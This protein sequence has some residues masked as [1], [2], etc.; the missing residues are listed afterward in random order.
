MGMRKEM[1]FKLKAY[2]TYS[3]KLIENFLNP[4]KEMAIQVQV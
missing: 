1:R 2:E 4:E 3:I